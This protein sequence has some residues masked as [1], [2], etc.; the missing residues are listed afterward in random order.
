MTYIPDKEIISKYAKVMVNFALGN[1]KGIKKGET[2]YIIGPESSK[3]LFMEC[4]K[5]ITESGGNCILNYLPDGTDRFG[6]GKDTLEMADYKQLNFAPHKY[7]KGLV[8][9]MDHYLYIISESDPNA[10]KGVDPKKT[11]L[12]QKAFKPFMEWRSDKENQ[13]KLSWTLC[14]YP[15]EAMA[16]EAGMTLGEYWGQV[17]KACFLEEKDPIKKWNET[18]KMINSTRDKLNKITKYI[19]YLHVEGVDVDLK[20]KVGEYRKWLSGSGCNIPS[21][22]VFTSPDTRGT[23]GWIK[24]NQPLYRF[25]NIIRD[26]KLVFK[27]GKV[28]EASASEGE[29]VLLEMIKS[30][31]ANMVGEFSLTDKRA[32]QITKFMANTLYDENIGGEFGNTHIA[33]GNSYVTTCT[34]NI[35]KMKQMD[36]E[37]LGYNFSA[38]HTDIIST[39]DR[40]VTAYLKNG[41]TKIIYKDGMFCL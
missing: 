5:V 23:E 4:L 10:L 17:K 18:F 29:K 35:K 32:S 34:K 20:I 22:E 38:I 8:D 24:F 25:G 31:Q 41:K 19:D 39:T 11:M 3:P 16:K 26:V 1:G 2:V 7:L 15:T 9:E 36:F 28:V 40:T 30:P 37:K 12:R 27:K 6:H 13:G 14:L 21:F 33:L